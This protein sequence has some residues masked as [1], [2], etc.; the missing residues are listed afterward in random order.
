[1]QWRVEKHPEVVGLEAPRWKAR[2]SSTST[3][4]GIAFCMSLRLE[5]RMRYARLV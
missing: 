1:M 5:A 4:I 2:S 3:A